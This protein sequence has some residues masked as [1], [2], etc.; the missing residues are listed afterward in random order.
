VA[1]STEPSPGGDAPG[2]LADLRE[3]LVGREQQAIAELR[4]R[5]D[6][7]ELTPEEVA[8]QLP[9][10]IALRASRDDRLAR[11][12]A[13]TL[14]SAIGESVQ[15]NPEQIAQAI[16]PSLGPAIRKAISE[17][18]AG[19]VASINHAIEH[20][21]SWQGLKW[22]LEAWRTGVPYPQIVMRHA[23][24]YRVEQ[25]YLIHAE[26][27]L[28]LAHVAAPDLATPDADL[29]SGMLTA[30]RDFVSDSFN[31]GAAGG[32]RTFTVGELTVMVEPGPK[33]LLAA[34]VRGEAPPELLERLQR[35]LETLH[36]RF[37]S[38]LSHFAGDAAPFEPARP[39][40]A[41]C[42]EKVLE[43]DRPRRRSLAPRIAWGLA[44]LLVLALV[45][46]AILSQ[47]RWHRSIAALRAQPGLVV[48]EAGRSL[49]GWHLTGLRDP[50]AADPQAV[51][52]GLGVDTTGVRGSW[53]PYLSADPPIVLA[54]AR[55]ALAAPAGV[56]LALAGD[57]L[58]ASGTADLEWLRD[59]PGRATGIPGV[60]RLDVTQVV[61]RLP[62]ALQ[63]L[64]DSIERSLVLFAPGSAALDGA[65]G[66]T[67][68]A[69]AVR[70]RRL[71]VA[72]P[73]AFEVAV[74]IVG[75]TDTTGSSE[76]NRPLSEQRARGV[77]RALAALGIAPARLTPIGA[78]AGNPLPADT[79]G[80]V[81]RRN[82]S[83]ALAV[84]LRPPAPGGGSTP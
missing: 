20:S 15:R 43:T 46:L 71:Q 73:P 44:L 18:M 84:R 70:L 22:R 65:A 64:A 62:A 8:E 56:S 30:I 66:A 75:R 69:A 14:E 5:L 32:L 61:P 11:A 16:Y 45:A 9:E 2:E 41:E 47:R 10:A 81:A 35:T 77:A 28:L 57:A 26:T 36:F 49:R 39:L 54:R 24:V 72:L 23:L 27:G 34:V 1:D 12:L 52:A 29:I 55:R 25:V 17:T 80:D 63:P 7:L 3:I 13:P 58:E 42:L 76:V 67:V 37:A 21:L 48:L 74:E 83:V 33:A 68:R 4:R 78:G 51:L 79:S 38:P 6:A 82:R 59:A 60:T 40:L 19:L 53:T 50:L 31:A